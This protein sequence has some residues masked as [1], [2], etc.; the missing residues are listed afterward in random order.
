MKGDRR[1]FLRISR[2]ATFPNGCCGA[3]LGREPIL[4]GQGTGSEW[5]SSGGLGAE[6]RFARDWAEPP[7]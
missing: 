7:D 6:A 4:R 3:R 1:T 5:L 2:Q